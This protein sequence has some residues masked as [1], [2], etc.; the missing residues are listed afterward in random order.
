M[1]YF[2]FEVAVGMVVLWTDSGTVSHKSG[3]ALF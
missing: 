1:A 3:T 2:D